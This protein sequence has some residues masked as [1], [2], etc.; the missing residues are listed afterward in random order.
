M[1]TKMQRRG[2]RIA[3]VFIAAIHM[4]GRGTTKRERAVEPYSDQPQSK[5]ARLSETRTFT[6]EHREGQIPSGSRDPE[7]VLQ[8]QSDCPRCS[9]CQPS[10]SQDRKRRADSH[11]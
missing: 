2:R 10:T 7:Q 6:K 5:R 11:L 3:K 4:T 1:L 8:P 9:P